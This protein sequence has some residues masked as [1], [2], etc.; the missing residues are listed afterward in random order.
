[1]SAFGTSP[2][3][4]TVEQIHEACNVAGHGVVEGAL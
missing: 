4:V 3:K 1:V 2:L